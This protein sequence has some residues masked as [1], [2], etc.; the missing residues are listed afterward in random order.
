LPNAPLM[1]WKIVV[2]F[3]AMCGTIL[4]AFFSPF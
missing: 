2:I 4:L 3:L 1:P